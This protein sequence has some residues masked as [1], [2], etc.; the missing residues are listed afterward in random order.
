M[1][2]EKYKQII[3]EAYK[4]YRSKSKDLDLP[5]NLYNKLID[6]LNRDSMFP[7]D[8]PSRMLSQEQFINKC[9]TDSEFSNTWGLKIE[10]RDMTWEERV[11]WVMKYTD[12]E[13]ENL[14]IVEEAHKETSPTRIS[15]IITDKERISIYL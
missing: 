1:N 15:T 10:E 2:K 8:N 12:V 6:D 7:I 5:E 13:L 3:D 4:N 11:Q 14:Y 9:K